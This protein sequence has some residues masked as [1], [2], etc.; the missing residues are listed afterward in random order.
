MRAHVPDSEVVTVTLVAVKYVAN[1]H[2]ITL[3]VMQK[4]I[5]IQRTNMHPNAT[6]NQQLLCMHRKRIEATIANWGK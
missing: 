2:R 5:A 1:N 3:V 4:I 6:V